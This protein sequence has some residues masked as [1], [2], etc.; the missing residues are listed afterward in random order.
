M[1]ILVSNLHTFNVGHKEIQPLKF[2]MPLT[3]PET[4]SDASSRV[5]EAG[6]CAK[7]VDVLGF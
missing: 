5:C 4:S 6:E 2:H 7:S 1:L 3:L